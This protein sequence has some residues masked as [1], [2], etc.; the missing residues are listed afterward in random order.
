MLHSTGGAASPVPGET[1]ASIL[2]AGRAPES[3]EPTLQSASF[4]LSLSSADRCGRRNS[5]AR[6]VQ[7][8][9]FLSAVSIFALEVRAGGG[10]RFNPSTICS[11][12][13]DCNSSREQCPR[14]WGIQISI[15]RF[16]KSKLFL[17]E[18]VM[19]LHHPCYCRFR[20]DR[21]DTGCKLT[22]RGQKGFELSST[23]QLSRG[24]SD[25]STQTLL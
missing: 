24:C 11:T 9:G 19:L 10:G 21:G 6:T 25:P 20:Q 4:L 14:L 1:G 22:P 16:Q 18:K 3:Q 12:R 13:L 15:F 7:K 17:L 5:A 8:P 2:G 23:N